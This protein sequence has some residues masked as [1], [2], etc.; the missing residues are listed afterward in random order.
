MSN[1]IKVGL[2]DTFGVEPSSLNGMIIT[3]FNETVDRGTMLEEATHTKL[4]SAAY[5]GAL[6]PSGSIDANIR[7][8]QMEALFNAIMGEKTVLTTPLRNQ[9]T[10]GNPKSVT[11]KVAEDTAAQKETIYTGCGISSV[12]LS[13]EP[14]DFVKS[15]WNWYAKDLKDSGGYDV[16]ILSDEKPI[17]FYRAIISIDG[18][19]EIGI[20]SLDMTI[21]RG[22][23]TDQF[24]IG[25]FKRYR[26]ANTSQTSI[27]GS[28]VFTEDSFAELYRA[29]YG[30]KTNM[31]VPSNNL[32]GRTHMIIT[33]LT[34][35][36]L[37]SI[38]IDCPIAVYDS[39]SRTFSGTAEVEKNVDYTIINDQNDPFRIVIYQ[40]K[41]L[42]PL[43]INTIT[44]KNT[45][46]S[47]ACSADVSGNPSYYK[48]D[49]GD[50]SDYSFE[51]SPTHIYN[52][53][54]TYTVTL[55]VDR[56]E[57]VSSVTS[58]EEITVVA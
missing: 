26:L 12:D 2:E 17:V 50:G 10:L 40:N 27:T 24:V 30:E 6:Q 25:S 44:L 23:D 13:F 8:L 37:N 22:M 32:L 55:T 34:P 43:A 53:A 45:D 58:T 3:D 16:P 38:I 7:P 36:G 21:D 18:N 54:G 9:Y 52:S 48:W 39:S 46:L 31:S 29:M 49:F 42:D 35:D 14:K 57:S 28:V 33:C 47:V 56:D 41:T 11:L 51:E 5:G 20:K 15:T 19:T 1:Y 4:P